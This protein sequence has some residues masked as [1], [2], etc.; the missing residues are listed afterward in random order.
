[1]HELSVTEN[2]VD[3]VLNEV[4]NRNIKKVTTINLVIGELTGFVN[5]SIKFYFDILSENTPLQG[6]ELKFKNV[7]AKFKCRKCGMT[8][9]RSNFTF[10]CPNCGANG[11]LIEN[12]K[13]FYIDSIDVEK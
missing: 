3:M 13:E 2:M 4:E 11:V 8:Y 10:K 1:M 12:G 5:D 6:A 9:N 7:K